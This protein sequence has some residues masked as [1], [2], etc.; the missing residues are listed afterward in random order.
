[1]RGVIETSG[2]GPRVMKTRDGWLFLVGGANSTKELFDA[3]GFSRRVQIEQWAARITARRERFAE[4]GIRYRMLVVPEKLSVLGLSEP[5][6]TEI[7]GEKAAGDVEPPGARFVRLVRDPAIVY[8][9]EFLTSQEARGYQTFART[10]SHWTWLGALSAFQL[11]AASLNYKFTLTEYFALRREEKR[12]R[13]DLWEEPFP[14]VGPDLFVRVAPPDWI[15]RVYCNSLVG[16]KE[17]NDLSN[18]AGLHAGCHC[19]FVN[20]CPAST[21]SVLLFGSSF[22]DYRLPVN[23]LTTIITTQFKVVHF[24]WSTEIDFDYVTRVRPHLVIAEIPERFLT[25]C[26]SDELDIESHAVTRLARWRSE[27]RP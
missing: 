8:P 3:E 19:V 1:M 15:R 16:F 17:A 11:L 10:D 20:D 27:T 2:T 12:Y 23:L 22:S 4:L 25:M 6:R 24:V 13:G 21:D 9:L 7:F 14:D 18:A 5:R 26:P